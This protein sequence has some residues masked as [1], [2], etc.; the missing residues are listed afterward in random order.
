MVR[1]FVWEEGTIGQK[2]VKSC[3]PNHSPYFGARAKALTDR[4]QSILKNTENN[5]RQ[6]SYLLLA[7]QICTSTLYVMIARPMH[8]TNLCVC[9]QSL[10]SANPSIVP[11]KKHRVHYTAL[12]NQVYVKLVH[13]RSLVQ[14]P[15]IKFRIE[16]GLRLY[17]LISQIVW[18]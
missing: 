1:W 3:T 18:Q 7:T 2:Q 16:T 15:Y 11:S 13:G 17:L 9:L 5:R 14:L 6:Y 4:L 12:S 10:Y 8:P